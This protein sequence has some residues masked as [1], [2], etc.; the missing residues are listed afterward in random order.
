VE[1]VFREQ[2]LPG[3][4]YEPD[5]DEERNFRLDFY[6]CSLAIAA[7]N[8]L[9]EA[10]MGLRSAANRLQPPELSTL[11]LKTFKEEEFSAAIKEVVCIWIHQEAVE[12]GGESVPDWLRTFFRLAFGA[13]DYMLPTP[14]AWE[15]M[16]AYGRCRDMVSLCMEACCRVCVELGFGVASIT[17][18]PTVMPI[19]LQTGELRQGVLKEALSLPLGE[20]RERAHNPVTPGLF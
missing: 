12:Q 11:A 20:L 13:A 1:D 4:E 15:V 5:S 10:L 8:Q 14:T 2:F 6:T 16:H 17:F 9:T 19:V 18:S 7:S 3:P